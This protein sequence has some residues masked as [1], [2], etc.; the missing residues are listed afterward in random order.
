MPPRLDASAERAARLAQPSLAK[1]PALDNL[2]AF[3]FA[4]RPSAAKLLLSADLLN[5]LRCASLLHLLVS[6]AVDGNVVKS[7][8]SCTS[9]AHDITHCGPHASPEAKGQEAELQHRTTAPG[10]FG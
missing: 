8:N 2:E 4:Q 7:G 5:Q 9:I 6:G 1:P 10:G 3:L